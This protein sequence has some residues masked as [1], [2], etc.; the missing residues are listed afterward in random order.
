M[1][2]RNRGGAVANRVAPFTPDFQER[3]SINAGAK[4]AIAACAAQLISDGDWIIM[5]AGSTVLYV[6]DH[7]RARRLTVAVN[8]VFTANKLVDAPS[9]DLIQIG[10]FL[11]RPALCF[12]GE[13]A[14]AHVDAM[15]FDWLFLGVNGVSETGISVNNTMEV[16]IKQKMI[17][18]ADQVVV[19]ADATKLGLRSLARIA[20]LSSV[21]KLVTDSS[22][23]PIALEALEQAHPEMEVLI[24]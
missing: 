13:L 3:S 16:G 20:P 1:L 7:L 23:D 11:H 14:I 21:H 6:A 2:T 24:A 12:V 9:V 17:A 10:G 22:A 5:D 18:S 15:H 4:R 19:L 8:S